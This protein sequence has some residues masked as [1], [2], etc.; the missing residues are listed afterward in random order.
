VISLVLFAFGNAPQPVFVE[1]RIS[2]SIARLVVTEGGSRVDLGIRVSAREHPIGPLKIFWTVAFA[3]SE[4]PWEAAEFTS[5][6]RTV[7]LVA[8]A[9]SVEVLWPTTELLL[10]RGVHDVSLWVHERE[11]G[12]DFRHLTGGS[13]GR[14]DRAEPRPT[15][16]RIDA[17]TFGPRSGPG[18]LQFVGVEQ[19]AALD[20]SIELYSLVR[21]AG[22]EKI[23]LRFSWLINR[24][25]LPDPWR[26]PLWKTDWIEVADVNPGASVRF[27]WGGPIGLPQGT[28]GISTWL[29]WREGNDWI[30]SHSSPVIPV[31]I[32]TNSSGVE[33]RGPPA[34]IQ[35]TQAELL[36]PGTVS[37]FLRETTGRPSKFAVALQG[38]EEERHR[39]WATSPPGDLATDV[40]ELAA[41]EE[42]WIAILTAE[43]VDGVSFARIT[44]VPVLSDMGGERDGNEPA[45]RHGEGPVIEDVLVK[46]CP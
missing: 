14:I 3:G 46:S 28:Y 42:R 6:T 5:E 33:R 21:N 45:L 29:Q 12:G 39:E 10:P 44:L 19:A 30:H 36:R 35:I 8:P 23:T 26:D 11:N 16:V 17:P 41:D 9:Q 2:V 37:I 18:A 15:N 4:P 13:I 40:Y 32:G 25:R 34:G 38:V 20:Q 43:C 7:E 22:N 24:Y 1:P 31:E 27:D